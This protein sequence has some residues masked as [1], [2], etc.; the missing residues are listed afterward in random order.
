MVPS[1]VVAVH[2][3]VAVLFRDDLPAGSR[4]TN[5]V[6]SLSAFP[7]IIIDGRDHGRADDQQRVNVVF[8]LYPVPD[9]LAAILGHRFPVLPVRIFID[10]QMVPQMVSDVVYPRST[11]VSGEPCGSRN[12]V[13][14]SYGNDI[15]AT[16]QRSRQSDGLW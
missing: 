10:P 1:A 13:C 14:S 16:A 7:Q 12:L 8:V 2:A 11:S 9:A 6:L 15:Y 5:L 4:H 3:L